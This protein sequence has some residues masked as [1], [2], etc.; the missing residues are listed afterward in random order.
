MD[1]LEKSLEDIIFEANSDD[2]FKRGL[3]VRG[4]KFRQLKIGSYGVADLITARMQ[5][6]PFYPKKFIDITIFE[7]KK[8]LIDIGAFMQSIRYA[9]GIMSYLEKRTDLPVHIDIKLVGK[10][11]DLNTSLIYLTDLVTH[12]DC[13]SPINGVKSINFYTYQYKFDGIFFNEHYAYSITNE[14]FNL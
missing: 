11:M 4:K 12:D 10:R 6:T 5:P 8:D 3:P 9:K 7:L 14:G 1:F 13:H 2:L